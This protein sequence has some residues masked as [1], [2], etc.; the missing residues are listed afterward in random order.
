MTSQDRIQALKAEFDRSFADAHR[1]DRREFESFLA[2]RLAGDPYAL[3]LK[4][5]A[6]LA[7]RPRIVPLPSR[8]AEFLGMTGHRGSLAALF[9]LPLLLG[10]GRVGGAPRWFVL[11]RAASR[12]A[13]GFDDYDGYAR[14]ATTE[15]HAVGEGARRRFASQALRHGDVV[16]LI[17]DLPALLDAL[18]QDK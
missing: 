7:A 17:V 12:V 5:I 11:P 18:N 15:I 10:Y 1:E 14:V 8:R 4:D 6:A 16:R 2:V 3:R 13:L 9:S